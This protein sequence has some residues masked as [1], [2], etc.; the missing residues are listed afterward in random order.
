MVLKSF[1]MLLNVRIG[2]DPDP[3]S[4]CILDPHADPHS[5]RRS[6]S[7]GGNFVLLKIIRLL[8]LFPRARNVCNK[9]LHTVVKDG[10]FVLYT[11]LDPDPYWI[12]IY[13]THTVCGSETLLSIKPL[14]LLISGTRSC[15]LIRGRMYEI[16]PYV[17]F[18]LI[19]PL[20][21]T[22]NLI[23]I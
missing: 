22:L 19:F 2:F 1:A 5:K 18:H 21:H 4:I 13:T 7:M 8:L 6:G 3:H 14:Y 9:F 20:I 10:T 23:L 15:Q 11:K 17:F 12:R 16:F